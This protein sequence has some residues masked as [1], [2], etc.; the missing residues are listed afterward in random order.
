MSYGSKR[1]ASQTQWMTLQTQRGVFLMKMNRTWCL[2]RGQM[3]KASAYG[4]G[5]CK[6]ETCRGHYSSRRKE[7]LKAAPR[8][9]EPLRAGSNGFRVHLLNRPDTMSMLKIVKM[10]VHVNAI[11]SVPRLVVH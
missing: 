8:G 11:E 1:D 6:F 5:G 7:Q 9:S 10:F 2:P 4:A 3:D